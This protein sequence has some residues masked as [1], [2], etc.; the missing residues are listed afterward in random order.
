MYI[1]ASINMYNLFWKPFMYHDVYVFEAFSFL[2]LIK[3]NF[4][5]SAKKFQVGGEEIKR[6]VVKKL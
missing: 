1:I 2:T 5:W 3:I 4:Y 6:E